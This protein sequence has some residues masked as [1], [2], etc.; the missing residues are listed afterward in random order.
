MSRMLH[1]PASEWGMECGVFLSNPSL[2]QWT[3]EHTDT[4]VTKAHM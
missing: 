2:L 1:Y 4:H 3:Y